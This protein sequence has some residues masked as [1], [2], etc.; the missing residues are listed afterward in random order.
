MDKA[1]VEQKLKEI[2]DKIVKEFQPEK[3]ILFGSWAWGEPGPDSDIDLLIVKDSQQSRIER[4][5]EV[6]RL[7]YPR[8]LPIDIL[9]YTP[10]ELEKSINGNRNLFLEDIVRNGKV[11]YAKPESMLT[12]T[13]PER[14]LTVLR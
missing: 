2:T 10:E 1:L 3:V 7:L 6:S 9:A 14:S 13:L 12:V 11:L 4:E 5:R 8:E